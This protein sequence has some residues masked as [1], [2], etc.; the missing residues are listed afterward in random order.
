MNWLERIASRQKISDAWF[1]NEPLL[2]RPMTP[3]EKKKLDER[4]RGQWMG[5]KRKVIPQKSH[6]LSSDFPKYTTYADPVYKRLGYSD[7]AAVEWLA[8]DESL[9]V[10]Y[11]GKREK[12]FY[13]EEL[14]NALS[15]NRI[16]LINELVLSALLHKGDQIVDGQEFDRV[17]ALN[18]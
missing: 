2:N 6:S 18:K 16:I 4:Q 13:K 12:R 11:D 14:M 1:N 17:M 10:L 8:E 3:E 5:D 15:E 7:I 9:R